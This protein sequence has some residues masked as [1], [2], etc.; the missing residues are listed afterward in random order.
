MRI[1]ACFAH[2]SSFICMYAIPK[3]AGTPRREQHLPR[4]SV[5]CFFVF[6]GIHYLVCECGGLVREFANLIIILYERIGKIAINFINR[7]VRT[8]S[9]VVYIRSIFWCFFFHFYIC[10]GKLFVCWS[11]T[12]FISEL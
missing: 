3:P 5:R 4:P 8:H 12:H 6:N 1:H 11:S 9:I 7:A 2:Q 10:N